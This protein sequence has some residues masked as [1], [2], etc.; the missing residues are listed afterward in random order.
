MI[1]NYLSYYD[2]HLLKGGITV[3]NNEYLNDSMV[4]NRVKAAVK[5][6]IEKQEAM[7]VEIV[8]FDPKDNSLYILNKDGTKRIVKQNVRKFSEYD[9]Q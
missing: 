9:D 5:L 6:A 8:R 1:K 3:K 7:G 4:V 2:F